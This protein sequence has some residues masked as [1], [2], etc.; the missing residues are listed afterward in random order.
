LE[1][2]QTAPTSAN[3]YG[4]GLCRWSASQA[5]LVASRYEDLFTRLAVA[6]FEK[7]HRFDLF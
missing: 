5:K 1:W 4:C 6:F 7:C 3:F 2:Q